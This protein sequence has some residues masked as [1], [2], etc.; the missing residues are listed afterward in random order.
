MRKKARTDTTRRYAVKLLYQYAAVNP[1]R[2]ARRR[3][4]EESMILIKAKSAREALRLAKR[5]ARRRRFSFRTTHG[6]EVAFEFVGILDLLRLG[7]ECQP[8]EVWYDIIQL[9]RP[10]ERRRKLIPPEADL[11]AIRWEAKANKR[12][13][14][15]G[16]R[17]RRHSQTRRGAGCSAVPR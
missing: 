10:M 5:H 11:N 15:P 1:R 3:T 9:V 17:A 4:C 7:A 6:D 16:E 8:E 12:L 13:E 14:R 2:R